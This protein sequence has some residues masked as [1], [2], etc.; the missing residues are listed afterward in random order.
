[1]G[2][3]PLNVVTVFRPFTTCE[4]SCIPASRHFERSSS[5]GVFIISKRGFW[6]PGTPERADRGRRTRLHTARCRLASQIRAGILA[7]LWRHG[8]SGG[9]VW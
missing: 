2:P 8:G 5:S 6:L 4:V 1:M 9:G 3:W 7:S